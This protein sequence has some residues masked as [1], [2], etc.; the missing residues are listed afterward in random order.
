[1]EKLLIINYLQNGKVVRDYGK[2]ILPNLLTEVKDCIDNNENVIFTRDSHNLMIDS[3]DWFIIP[4]IY[5]FAIEE[6]SLKRIKFIDISDP[7]DSTTEIVEAVTNFIRAKQLQYYADGNN[8]ELPAE[9]GVKIVGCDSKMIARIYRNIAKKYIEYGK[10]GETMN[11]VL[12]PNEIITDSSE[13]CEDEIASLRADITNSVLAITR[14]EK[15]LL[16]KI[17]VL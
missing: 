12:D 17:K 9:W 3:D 5:N 16:A 15:G 7:F 2:A 13:K 6:A 14:S 4:E 8:E 11:F 1:M 10:S